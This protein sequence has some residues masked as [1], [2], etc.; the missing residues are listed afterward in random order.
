M[1][2][3]LLTLLGLLLMGVAH[4]QMSPSSRSSLLISGRISDTANI[5]VIGAQIFFLDS[6]GTPPMMAYA[7][8]GYNGMYSI[9]LYGRASGIVRIRVVDCAGNM[10]YDS[11]AY[12]G[13]GAHVR[14]FT[15]ACRIRIPNPPPPPTAR[16]NADFSFRPDTGLGVRYMPMMM[17]TTLGYSWSFGDGNTSTAMSPTHYYTSGGMY[18]VRLI[19][20]RIGATASTSC[21]DTESRVVSVPM[22]PRPPV[23]N[24]WSIPCN[25]RFGA[26]ID[27]T[28]TVGFR[29]VLQ[30]TTV[31][32]SWNFGD[33]TTSIGRNPSHTYAAAGQYVVVLAVSRTGSS[34]SQSC[35]DTAWMRI[36]VP[37]YRRPR[38]ITNP[39]PV[40]PPAPCASTYMVVPD[41]APLGYVFVA[42][43]VSNRRNYAWTFGDGSSGTGSV[44][45]HTYASAG[46][47]VVCLT[48]TDSVSNCTFNRC[49]TL[50]ASSL[51]SAN[52]GGLAP[53]TGSS[54]ASGSVAEVKLAV[55]PNPVREALNLTFKGGNGQATVRVMDLTGRVV[56]SQ[57][58]RLSQGI[59]QEVLQVNDLPLGTYVLTLD[60][61]GKREYSRF[62]KN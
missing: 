7:G 25:P 60:R 52:G 26:R 6:S 49:D 50:F 62:V 61:E 46:S 8:S 27:T 29:S 13:S 57:V 16:C 33:G 40:P 51:R 36:S 32:Y 19:V 10:Y 34:A 35:T 20:R 56:L 54:N 28:F 9:R 38:V 22:P 39:T 43:P 14:N 24:P 15:V 12:S 5:G 17:D 44:V 55:Y 41:T 31:T 1:K 37:G 53:R 45:R 11:V 4:A 58:Y 18:T 59:Q 48:V 3:K 47:Y 23:G 42:R 21:S 30:D 2:N